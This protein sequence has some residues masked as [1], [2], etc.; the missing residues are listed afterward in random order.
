MAY[1]ETALYCDSVAYTAVAQ[2]A[3]STAYTVGQIRRQLAAPTAGHERCFVCYQAGT[4]GASEPTGSWLTA[5]KGQLFITDGTVRWQECTALPALNGDN[6]NTCVWRP[7][8]SGVLQGA[9]IKNTANTHY[10]IQNNGG[11]GGLATEPTWNTTAGA[12]TA[13]GGSL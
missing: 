10:F 4:S 2:W 8:Q 13:E 12:S 7:S 9:I 1:T 11:S 3:A 6:T 5:A